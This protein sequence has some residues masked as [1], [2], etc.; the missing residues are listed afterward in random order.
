MMVGLPG[1]CLREMTREQAG[2][3]VVG[4]AGTDRD[5]DGDGLAAVEVALLRGRRHQHG[6][7]GAALLPKTCLIWLPRLA[8]GLLTSRTLAMR[9]GEISNRSATTFC[10][11]SP[12]RGARRQ[13][14]LGG[15]GLKV[16]VG[17]HRLECLTQQLQPGRRHVRCRKQRAAD[18]VVGDEMPED[19]RGIR[20][21]GELEH[22][23]YVWHIGDRGAAR[24]AP[25][26]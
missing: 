19:L 10:I 15:L 7:A 21:A 25:G 1:R 20:V 13:F 5:D 2:V 3:G 6:G 14:E 17:D 26:C 4:A 12:L 11:S 18:L 23:R 8:H 9:G 22:G 24:T 16:C